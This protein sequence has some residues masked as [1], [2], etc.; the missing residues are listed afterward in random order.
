MAVS[1]GVEVCGSDDHLLAAEGGL[2]PVPAGDPH[3]VGGV[4]VQ[5]RHGEL[6][7]RHW[8]PGYKWLRRTEC[9][10]VHIFHSAQLKVYY[11]FLKL[12]KK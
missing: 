5:P 8:D 3:G 11:N 9:Y 7:L 4:T 1:G 10:C 12:S 2:P 6:P